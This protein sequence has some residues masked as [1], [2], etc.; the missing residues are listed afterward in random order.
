MRRLMM[1]GA[2]GVLLI[3]THAVA[4]GQSKTIPGRTLTVTATVESIDFANR[5]VVGKKPDGTYEEFYFPETFKRF[6]TLKVGDTITA[7]ITALDPSVPS[8]TFTGP[9]GWKYS[10]RVEDTAALAK[11]KVGDKVDLTWTE[12][13]I[14]SLEDRK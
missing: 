8:V 7:T 5:E 2:A 6:D 9:N 1:L 4:A 3:A 13:T 12:A 10:T 14:L 11:V